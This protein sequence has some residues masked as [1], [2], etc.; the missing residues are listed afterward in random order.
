M[1]T[2]NFICYGNPSGG[3]R[4]GNA[5][6]QTDRQTDRTKDKTKLIGSFRDY[7][8]AHNRNINM[9]LCYD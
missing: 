6:R 3:W 5:D 2:I 1:K 4:A 9:N 8:R 7:A